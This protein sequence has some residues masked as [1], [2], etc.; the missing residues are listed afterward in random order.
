[1]QRKKPLLNKHTKWFSY[2]LITSQKSCCKESVSMEGKEQRGTLE[3][4]FYNIFEANIL[5][6]D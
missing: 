2:R 6:L 4:F 1:M 3:V 5:P